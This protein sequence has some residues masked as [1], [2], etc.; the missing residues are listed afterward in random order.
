MNKRDFGEWGVKLGVFALA[1]LVWFHAVT[2]LSYRREL[3]IPLVVEDPPSSPPAGD[4]IVA[5]P[6]P[7]YVTVVVS[8]IGKD[9]LA[10]SGDEFLLRVQ[11][12]RGRRGAQLSFRLSPDQVEPTGDVPVRV[13]E[14]K[15]PREL[16]V[17]LDRRVERE[18]PVRLVMR[19]EIAD[20]YTQVGDTGL[21]PVSV[22]VSGPASHIADL[23]SVSTDSLVLTAISED[24]SE[25]VALKIPSGT[26]LDLSETHVTVTLDIQE[27]AGDFSIINVPVEVRNSGRSRTT[28]EPS[29]VSVRV[30]GG[31]D[32]IYS[33]TETD[34]GL[35][36]DYEACRDGRS[37]GT[38]LVDADKSFEVLQ[39]SPSRVRIVER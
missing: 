39:I 28:P 25:R 38:I 16:T 14:V 4:I 37:D 7:E 8:G 35:Y 12:T 23:S 30:K 29:R 22:T 32:V 10:L 33:L 21:D 24:V 31:A 2:E 27:L 13:E 17:V 9:L 3:S 26:R 18:L 1:A 36:V 34:I 11:P 5:N 19:L 20:S 6:T 15:E